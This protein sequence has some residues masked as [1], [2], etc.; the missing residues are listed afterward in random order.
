MAKKKTS[1]K[2][3]LKK[4]D[5]VKEETKPVIPKVN[6]PVEPSKVSF[7]QWWLKLQRKREKAGKKKVPEHYREVVWADFNSRGSKENETAKR[8]NEL[9]ELFGYEK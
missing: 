6:V 9:F 3:V 5:P 4:P 2:K 1:K 8:F 7:E